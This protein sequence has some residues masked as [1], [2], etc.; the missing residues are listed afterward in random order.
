MGERDPGMPSALPKFSK[1]LKG[2]SGIGIQGSNIV[3]GERV[4]Q[5]FPL[6]GITVKYIKSYQFKVTCNRM[7]VEILIGA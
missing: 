5:Q 2:R 1:K 4:L 3:I 6:M 7:F